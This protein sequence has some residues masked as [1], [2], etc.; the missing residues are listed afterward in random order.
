M[1]AQLELDW[2]PQ[3]RTLGRKLRGGAQ[4]DLVKCDDG[5]WYCLKLAENPQHRRILVNEWLAGAAIRHLGLRTPEQQIVR[6]TPE[7]IEESPTF[8][9]TLGT[10]LIRPEPGYALASRW[11]VQNP[12]EDACYDYLPDALMEKVANLRD[13][14]MALAVDKWLS[15]EDSRQ[16][17]FWRE[18]GQF[19]LSLID[20]G[21]CFC[22]PHWNAY[23]E[24]RDVGGIYC[25][26]N[27]YDGLKL[28][29]YAETLGRI[30]DFPARILRNA[31]EEIP[32]SWLPGTDRSEAQT[33]IRQV[34]GRR[35]AVGGAVDAMLR[36][37]YGRS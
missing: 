29:D 19:W 21:Y 3:V 27:I 7:F 37:L 5:G 9:S 15:N 17:S 34:M 31:L 1:T 20:Q 22:G 24:C 12:N 10:R 35:T 25:R 26:R 8:G 14:Q 16:V 33:L 6:V 30:A 13:L 32:D 18:G 4:A 36:R 23:E 2:T 28:A 11:V